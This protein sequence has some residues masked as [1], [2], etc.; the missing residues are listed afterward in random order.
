[1]DQMK[2]AKKKLPNRKGRGTIVSVAIKK[3]KI[4]DSLTKN[5]GAIY[6]AVKDA[7]VSR[8]QYYKYL[9]HDPIFNQ[10]VQD[11]GEAKLDLAEAVLQ[12]AI[13]AKNMTAIIFF[14]KTKGKRRGYIERQEIS[15]PEGAPVGQPVSLADLGL[16]R[17]TRKKIVEEMEKRAKGGE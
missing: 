8:A 1:M 9:K 16:S 5:D 17:E 13:K 6:Q 2:T 3:R 4:L 10:A 12:K 15:G 7:G 11:L 14:L